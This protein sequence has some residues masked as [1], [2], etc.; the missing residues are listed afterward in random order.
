MNSMSA[1]SVNPAV[2]L[3]TGSFAVIAALSVAVSE[4]SAAKAGA[5]LTPT[6]PI[7]RMD[8]AAI[9]PARRANAVMAV[10]P[11]CRVMT[12]CEE[13]LDC[14]VLGERS[15]SPLYGGLEVGHLERVT[16]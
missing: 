5:A 8:A 13:C 11:E 12:E 7:P 2:R 4:T 16:R 1:V 9:M 14:T 6:M 3:M 15:G 10:P